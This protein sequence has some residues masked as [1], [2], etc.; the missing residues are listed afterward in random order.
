ARVAST[1][2][3]GSTSGSG[4]VVRSGRRLLARK[5]AETMATACPAAMNSSL[6]STASTR[7][8]PGAGLP[9]LRGSTR[10]KAFGFVPALIGIAR[11]K[12]VSAYPGDGANR[13]PAVHRLDAAHLFRLALEAAPACARL[14]GVDDEGVPFRDIADVIG[15][16]LKL[17]V[18]G[19][20]RE[21]AG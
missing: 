20:P 8:P 14:H 5:P 21:E 15:R 12:G 17:Q 13:W 7:G 6:S 3:L 19:I 16:H 9:S 10:Q 11:A 2:W 4:I 18:T 1:T